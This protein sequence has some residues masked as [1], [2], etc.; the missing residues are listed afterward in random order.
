MNISKTHKISTIKQRE[1]IKYVLENSRKIYT[2][3]GIIFLQRSEK[4]DEMKIA[5]LVK[6]SCGSAVKRNYIKR[7]IRH[8]TLDHYQYL[9]RF[10]R[11]IFLYNYRENIDYHKLENIFL[12]A[13]C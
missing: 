7:I 12:K 6:K 4:N 11:I 3:L 9:K 2:R 8:F 13:I 1:E 10:N 5:I